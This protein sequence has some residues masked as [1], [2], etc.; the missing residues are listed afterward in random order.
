MDHSLPLQRLR[1]GDR[2]THWPATVPQTHTH[3]HL[4]YSLQ[5]Q[6]TLAGGGGETGAGFAADGEFEHFSLLSFFLLKMG[7]AFLHTPA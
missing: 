6:H 7:I 5:H 1:G 2:H 4:I 3:T